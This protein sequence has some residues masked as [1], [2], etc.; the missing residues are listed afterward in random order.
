[1]PDQIIARSDASA[2]IPEEV[3]AEIFQGVT[4][5][6]A[7]LAVSRRL[8][9]MSRKQLRMPV[10]DSLPMAYFVD[11]EAPSGGLKRTTKMAWA[12]KFINAEEI[13]V[14]VPIPEAV[15]DD[16]DYDLWAEARPKLEEAFAAVIDAA[17]L[18]GTGA[19][20]SWPEGVVPDAIAAGNTVAFGTGGDL[21]DDI[22]GE[23]GVFSL[24]EED[25]YMVTGALAHPRMKGRLRGLRESGTGQP[26]FMRAQ[27][28]GQNLQNATRYELDGATLFFVNNGTFDE[29]EALMVAG[30]WSQL[31]YSVRQ[32]ITYKVLD[33]AVISNAQGEI[34]LNL[35]QQDAVALRAV[36]RIG[37]QLPNPVN[38]MNLIKG[39]A[40]IGE[41]GA[42]VVGRHPFAVLAPEV[43]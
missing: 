24:V 16:A 38:R 8:Q 32:D 37:W 41:A 14:I 34:I 42:D 28:D 26:I 9:N 40:G 19:P 27:P 12:N 39:G 15:L 33:Q 10:L 30:D 7:V 5:Q 23:S 18:F 21:Y 11:G 2:L 20:A 1:M 35:A 4:T 22:L 13:A 25:G 3:T 17:I 29:N 31:V 43:V 36:M 6:S